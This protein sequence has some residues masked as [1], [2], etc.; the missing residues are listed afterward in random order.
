LRKFSFTDVNRALRTVP[1]VRIYEEDGF[2]LRPNI[3][4]RGTS[5]ERSSKITLMEDGVFIASDS[6]SASY[7]FYFLQFLE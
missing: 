4:L 3:S 5:P 2:G 7:A 6:N 1:G